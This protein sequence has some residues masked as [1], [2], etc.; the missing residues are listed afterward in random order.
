MFLL[1]IVMPDLDGIEGQ[2]QLVSAGRCRLILLTAKV[3]G[4]RAKGLGP[5]PDETLQAVLSRELARAFARSS[6]GPAGP[7]QVPSSSKFD[8]VDIDLERRMFTRGGVVSSRTEWLLL[9]HRRQRGKVGPTE[10]DKG[11]GPEYRDDLQY[12]G[13]G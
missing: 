9:Q 2:A 7:I 13:L 3:D 8:H 4:D 1:D 11:R 6:A 10:P 5:L 12:L